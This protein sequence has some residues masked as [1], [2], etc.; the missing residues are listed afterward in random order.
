MVTRRNIDH[1]ERER[2]LKIVKQLTI[3]LVKTRLDSISLIYILFFLL[4][5]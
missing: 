3:H 4:F 1:G 2:E 5:R